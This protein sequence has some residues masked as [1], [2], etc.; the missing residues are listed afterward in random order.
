MR[1]DVSEEPSVQQV[2]RAGLLYVREY[3]RKR[4]AKRDLSGGG[5]RQYPQMSAPLLKGHYDHMLN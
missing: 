2:A 4:R 1:T 5:T 3:V